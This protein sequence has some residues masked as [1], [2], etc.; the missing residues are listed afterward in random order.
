MSKNERMPV[1][2]EFPTMSSVCSVRMSFSAPWD[3]T[4]AEKPVYLEF[5]HNQV[6][7]VLAGNLLLPGVQNN[8]SCL[9]S[10]ADPKVPSNYSPVLKWPDKFGVMLFLHILLSVIKT[11]QSVEC[12]LIMP[13]ALF[14]FSFVAV[15]L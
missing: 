4:H 3:I 11:M 14:T 1:R 13:P 2:S 7:W 6:P 8:A 5:K 12:A 10:H 15:F 9:I